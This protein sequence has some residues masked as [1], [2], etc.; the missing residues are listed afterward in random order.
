MCKPIGVVDRNRISDARMT[1]SSSY[2]SGYRPSYGRLNESS[3][4]GGWC[5][6]TNSDRTDYLQI[7]MG[8][9]RSVCGVATQGI[10]GSTTWTTSYKLQLSTNSITWNNYKETNIEKV[11]RELKL[12][13]SA[14]TKNSKSMQII[15]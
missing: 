13:F 14:I 8:E 4:L 11:W 10:R 12:T 15:S 5:P 7:D 9:V 6:T 1:A 2:S 3:G